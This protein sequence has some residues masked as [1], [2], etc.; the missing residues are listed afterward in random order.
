[1]KS[2]HSL[3]TKLKRLIGITNG[4][5]YFRPSFRWSFFVF[6]SNNMIKSDDELI[7]FVFIHDQIDGDALPNPNT[8]NRF[9][10]NDTLPNSNIELSEFSYLIECPRVEIER[11]ER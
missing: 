11:Q 9:D 10:N 6:Q 5:S 4:N 7:A 3:Q 8:R 2:K 1:M